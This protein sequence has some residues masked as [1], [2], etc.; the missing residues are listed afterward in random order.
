MHSSILHPKQVPYLTLILVLGI[1]DS[2]PKGF[3]REIVHCP[4]A[5]DAEIPT[6]KDCP[7]SLRFSLP[8]E[9]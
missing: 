6:F 8:L 4:Q 2:T 9:C 3:L 1:S 5:T 7:F